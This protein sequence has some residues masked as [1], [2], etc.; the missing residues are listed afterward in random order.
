VGS[1]DQPYALPCV[2]SFSHRP[3]T[4][5]RVDGLGLS[6][7]CPVSLK[8]IQHEA[9]A[10]CSGNRATTEESTTSFDLFSTASLY[11]PLP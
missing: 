3:I 6:M 7:I 9:E 4:C 11:F 2:K 8:T 10:Q 1:I 5:R